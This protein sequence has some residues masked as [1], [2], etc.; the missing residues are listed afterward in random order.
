MRSW[1]RPYGSAGERCM[2][3]SVAV[4]VGDDT[5]DDLIGRLKPRVESLKIGAY[6]ADGV[7]MGPLVTR[8][9]R[10]KV[11]G[12]VDTGVEEG[13]TLVVDGRDAPWRVTRRVSSSAAASSMT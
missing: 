12:Y 1:G 3:V 9:H 10:D 4:T 13:A 11:R 5:A 6:D 7:E 2:A 8:E